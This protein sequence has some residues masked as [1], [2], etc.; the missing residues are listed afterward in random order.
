MSLE[1][2]YQEFQHTAGVN[3]SWTVHVQAYY[4]RGALNQ[5]DCTQMD[6]LSGRFLL[7]RTPGA[8]GTQHGKLDT[9]ISAA[10]PKVL[11]IEI[12]LSL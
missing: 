1:S 4:I 5:L 10:K 12:E 2:R 9:A 11:R 8:N 3:L 7:S 6:Y